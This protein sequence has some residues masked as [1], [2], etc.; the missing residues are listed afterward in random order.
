MNCLDKGLAIQSIVRAV[1]K[2]YIEDPAILFFLCLPFYNLIG[3][4]EGRL[5]L[6]TDL[7]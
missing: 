2:G 7:S 6:R 5:G 1:C 4:R 3:M